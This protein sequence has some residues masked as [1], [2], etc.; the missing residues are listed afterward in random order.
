M[1]QV[2]ILKSVH[3]SFHYIG[4]TKNLSQRLKE[5]N[6][7]KV[8]STKSHKPYTVI[9]IEDYET[10]SLAQIREYYL[11]RGEGNIWLRNHLK[12]LQVW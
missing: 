8:R 10:K 11:K 12:E 3:G 7:G 4:H 1:Y 9:F 5:H 6:C 2:Y